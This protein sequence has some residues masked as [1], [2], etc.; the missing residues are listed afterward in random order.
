[1]T[2]AAV[3]AFVQAALSLIATLYVF[4]LATVLR[5][6]LGGADSAPAHAPAL[7]TEAT[8]LAIVQLAGVVA[9]VGGAVVAL[10]RR[11]RVAWFVLV[12]ALGTQLL[13][14]L[15][16]YIRLSMIADD[17]PAAAGGLRGSAI[18]FAAM[19]LVG[20]GLLLLGPGRR[21][22]VPEAA[23]PGDTAPSTGGSPAYPP[24][25]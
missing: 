16:W 23:V 3:L 8:V 11:G 2:A 6:G 14:S 21:W 1:V 12:S 18:M 25:P 24:N 15:Y 17:L 20:L 10:A 4:V 5:S 7:A 13:L 19:P 22:F 9:L